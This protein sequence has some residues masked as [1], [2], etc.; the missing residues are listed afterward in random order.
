MRIRKGF[1]LTYCTNIHAAE[2]WPQVFENLKRYAPELRNRL[3]PEGRFGLGLRLANNEAVELLSGS[4]LEE[5]ARV[6]AGFRALC[7]S[8]QRLP[9]WLVP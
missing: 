4:N 8:H 5:F 1:E 7:R 3:H 6:L 2:G 9:V